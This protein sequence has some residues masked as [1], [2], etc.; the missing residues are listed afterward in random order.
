MGDDIVQFS[1][2]LFIG[3][4]VI[5]SARWLEMTGRYPWKKMQPWLSKYIPYHKETGLPIIFL[6]S[7]T[8][9]TEIWGFR[10]AGTI[11]SIWSLYNLVKILL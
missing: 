11:F 2:F 9:E 1:V 4:V 5:L 7:R 3:I 8:G 10:I 6:R